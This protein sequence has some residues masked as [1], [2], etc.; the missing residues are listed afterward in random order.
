MAISPLSAKYLVS[1]IQRRTGARIVAVATL[2]GAVLYGNRRSS[3][4]PSAVM[5]LTVTL[6]RVHAHPLRSGL[7]AGDGVV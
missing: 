6:P 5:I 2:S 1:G 3:W 4:R 7:E